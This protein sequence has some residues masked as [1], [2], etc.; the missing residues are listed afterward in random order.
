M[1][2]PVVVIVDHARRVAA[3]GYVIGRE[4]R[5]V[6]IL[7]CVL[8]TAAAARHMLPC[9]KK[10]RPIYATSSRMRPK[11]ACDL[12]PFDFPGIGLRRNGW[13]RGGLGAQAAEGCAVSSAAGLCKRLGSYT[14]PSRRM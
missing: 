14:V 11:E 10:S 6:S 3:E 5:A 1:H 8:E 9:G 4:P 13:A 7:P 2:E 12:A